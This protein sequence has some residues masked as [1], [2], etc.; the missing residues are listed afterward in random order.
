MDRC[1]IC[2]NREGNTAHVAREMMYGF[3]TEFTYL[4]CARCGCV[5]IASVPDLDRY[6]PA[7][8][9]S[10]HPP[11]AFKV[12]LRGQWAAHAFGRFNPLGWLIT[13][14]FQRHGSVE[15]LRF[16]QPNLQE[17]VLDVG[18]GIGHYL[19]DL[20]H[21][22]FRSLA[23]VD[24][25]VPNDIHGRGFKVHKKELKDMDGEFDIIS[26]HHS[27][28]HMDHPGAVLTELAR[29]LAPEGTIILRIPVASSF[30]WKHYGVNW[31]N[32]DP[33]RHLFLHTP[34]TMERLCQQAGLRVHRTIFDSDAGQFWGSE[35]YVLG[36]PLTDSRSYAVSRR[37]SVFSRKQ[38]REFKRR[39]VELNE[40]GQGD[41]ACF[42]IR[43]EGTGECE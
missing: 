34:A 25:F 17:R 14:L 10:F 9:Y 7:D 4:E 12:F 30:A 2:E 43:H 26:L 16:L 31:V 33:P 19:M 39:A 35:Q 18:C 27:F 8:Y 23:G 40:K 24:P 36:I 41:L 42:Y 38:I 6:Y 29:L 21:L 3:R 37:R 11:N 15:A 32:L 22:G 13:R 28:E 5:Q 20:S 1:R